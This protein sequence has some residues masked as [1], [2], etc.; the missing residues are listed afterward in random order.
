MYLISRFKEKKNLRFLFSFF[1]NLT[2]Y[3]GTNH[4]NS[5]KLYFSFS[6]LGSGCWTYAHAVSHTYCPRNIPER[7]ACTS[8]YS[9]GSTVCNHQNCSNDSK[10]RIDKTSLVQIDI[11]VDPNNME[12][13]DANPHT[14]KNSSI[15]SQSSLCICST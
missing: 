3:L 8:R 5:V 13:R 9:Q 4:C 7:N 12:V 2:V 15:I 11:T 14:V 1:L 10:Y 6:S